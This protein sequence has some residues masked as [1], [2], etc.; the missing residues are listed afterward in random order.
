[1]KKFY[2][3]FSP[4]TGRTIAQTNK[5]ISQEEACP[6]PRRGDQKGIWG[7]YGKYLLVVMLVSLINW[8]VYKLLIRTIK[9][10]VDSWNFSIKYKKGEKEVYTRLLH[11][12]TPHTHK[13]NFIIYLIIL[14]IKPFRLSS[15][16]EK[17]PSKDYNSQR[18]AWSLLSASK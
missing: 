14:L 13:G 12:A 5:L 18:Q 15:G 8:I 11:K 16:P 17:K 6:F 3:I 4:V 10:E 9:K 2:V 1:M 7:R